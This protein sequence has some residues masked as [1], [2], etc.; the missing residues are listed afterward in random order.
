MLIIIYV[1]FDILRLF[2]FVKIYLF[3]NNILLLNSTIAKYA[4]TDFFAI[5]L[6]PILFFIFAQVF[7]AKIPLS[8]ILEKYYI[9][10]YLETSLAALSTLYVFFMGK[11]PSTLIYSL[12]G[13][14]FLLYYLSRIKAFFINLKKFLIVFGAALSCYVALILLLC[15]MLLEYPYEVQYSMAKQMQL[16]GNYSESTILVERY[17]RT[18]SSPN[19]EYYSLLAFNYFVLGLDISKA[20]HEISINELPQD[21]MYLRSFFYYNKLI[22]VRTLSPNE[23]KIYNLLKER[24]TE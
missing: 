7:N 17:I 19:P 4:L 14:V 6:L 13:P 8:A 24:F 12:L 3:T 23:D 5:I 11:T 21:R 22:K 15:I 10:V 20:G 1:L 16:E 2:Y 18:L 9:V